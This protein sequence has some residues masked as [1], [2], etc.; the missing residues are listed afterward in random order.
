MLRCA[1]CGAINPSVEKRLDCPLNYQH[2]E[3][4]K[5]TCFILYGNYVNN[6]RPKTNLIFPS[7]FRRDMKK[8]LCELK[9]S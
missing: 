1:F 3:F 9:E 8:R 2:F 6:K 5:T 7:G 4:C